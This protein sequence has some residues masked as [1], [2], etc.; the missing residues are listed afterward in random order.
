ML[1]VKQGKKH[2]MKTER[3][4]CRFVL[5]Q[6]EIHLEE[7][8]NQG[9][10]VSWTFKDRPDLDLSVLPRLQPCEVSKQGG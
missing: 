9:L 4:N 2:Q 5:G 7:I 1:K 8:Q 6:V 10:L 3:S